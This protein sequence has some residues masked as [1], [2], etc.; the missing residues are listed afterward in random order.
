MARPSWVS[1]WCLL[2]VSDGSFC[3]SPGLVD[4]TFLLSVELILHSAVTVSSRPTLAPLVGVQGGPCLP[5]HACRLCLV[6]G[7]LPFILHAAARMNIYRYSSGSG[8]LP[9][10]TLHGFPDAF[11]IKSKL[12]S[13][14]F[15]P[16]TPNPMSRGPVLRGSRRL[17]L[18]PQPHFCCVILS[19]LLNLY[20]PPC[21]C[22]S[23]ALRCQV[24]FSLSQSR[25]TATVSHPRACTRHS[26][27]RPQQLMPPDSRQ[28]L[29]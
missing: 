10:K 9:L 6:C 26:V 1:A 20:E 28:T 7:P 4:S 16:P 12:L 3:S 8:K 17:E 14:V 18:K 21:S 5:T 25:C 2:L 23:R 29:P 24:C 15:K 13:G 11:R 27:S 22:V 19:K